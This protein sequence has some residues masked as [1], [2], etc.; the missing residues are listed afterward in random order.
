MPQLN[1]FLKLTLAKD[2]FESSKVSHTLRIIVIFVILV[3]IIFIV[4]V[5]FNN[6]WLISLKEMEKKNNWFHS[7]SAHHIIGPNSTFFHRL[8][9]YNS[10]TLLDHCKEEEEKHNAAREATHSKEHRAIQSHHANSTG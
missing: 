9:G 1:H 4:I 2:T 6:D 7:Y 3:V 5:I 10:Q 8:A